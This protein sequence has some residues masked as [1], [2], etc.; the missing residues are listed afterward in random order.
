MNGIGIDY[1]PEKPAP[2][3]DKPVLRVFSKE[4]NSYKLQFESSNYKDAM[5]RVDDLYKQGKDVL[6]NEK[7]NPTSVRVK[8]NRHDNVDIGRGINSKESAL[9]VPDP[10]TEH[11]LHSFYEKLP[12]DT[13]EFDER[14]R[15]RVG[16]EPGKPTVETPGYQTRSQADTEPKVPEP[17]LKIKDNVGIDQAEPSGGPKP[18]L[19]KSG[20][21]LPE[22]LHEMYI[23]QDGKYHDRET[24]ALKFEDHG[25]SLSTSTEDRQIIAHMIEVAAAK[26][27]GKVELT[28]TET[29]KQTAWLE[30]ESRGIS[31][32]GYTPNERDLQQVA[33]LKSAANKELG[34]EKKQEISHSKSGLDPVL[35]KVP[36]PAAKKEPEPALQKAPEPVHE[37]APEPALGTVGKLIEHG[38][39]KYNFDPDE[40]QNYFVKLATDKGEKVVWGK[41]LK[42]AMA[43]SKAERGDSVLLEKPGSKP[44]TVSANVRDEQGKVIGTEPVASHLNSWNVKVIE[45][46]PTREVS[47]EE[48]VKLAGAEKVMAQALSKIPPQMRGEVLQKLQHAAEHGTLKLPVPK[49]TE[50]AKDVARPA[51]APNMERSR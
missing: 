17:A 47:G 19:Y 27:W 40:R 26:N 48:K 28:G 46:K 18:I 39:A 23:V 41:D 33:Q 16:K 22:K 4:G 45:L 7:D 50:R 42:R 21:K 29:F 30:A 37:K 1:S 38:P 32:K 15:S 20:Y 6:L 8:T 5:A 51:P 2:D 3:V 43:E 44:V 49:V 12:M 34:D 31:T 13:K 25:K 10:K 9:G 36:E 24:K 11:V 14:E 35:Q